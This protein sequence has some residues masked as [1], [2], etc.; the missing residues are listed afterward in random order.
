MWA[1]L[2][3][4][5]T[6]ALFGK[7]SP[8]L[9]VVLKAE[10]LMIILSLRQSSNFRNGIKNESSFLKYAVKLPG[11]RLHENMTLLWN[12]R[13]DAWT[14][15]TV[16][17]VSHR[18]ASRSSITPTDSLLRRFWAR[19]GPGLTLSAAAPLFSLGI[20]DSLTGGPPA[21]GN[22]GSDTS[23]RDGEIRREGE[24]WRLQFY[25]FNSF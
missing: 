7:R 5:R 4:S 15:R 21:S 17:L 6:L 12:S 2:F 9:S 23:M 18:S 13:A 24:T 3:K 14:L 11:Q 8:E 19:G 25:Q 1:L 10:Q 20:H 22:P 16:T